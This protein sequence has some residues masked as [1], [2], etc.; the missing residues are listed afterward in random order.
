MLKTEKKP[1]MER[2]NTSSFILRM[3]GH[4]MHSIQTISIE[5]LRRLKHNIMQKIYMNRLNMGQCMLASYKTIGEAH[6]N[7]YG[8]AIDCEQEF[9]ILTKIEIEK[10]RILFEQQMY[11][12]M[13][14]KILLLCGGSKIIGTLAP[15]PPNAT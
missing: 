12:S 2:R 10:E 3:Q 8:M 6:A 15:N 4:D 5:E 14:N 11:E 9:D 7:G 1:E 13:K